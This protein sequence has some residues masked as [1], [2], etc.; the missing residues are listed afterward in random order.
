MASNAG[1]FRV[2]LLVGVLSLGPGVTVAQSIGTQCW[3]NG[4][5]LQCNSQAGVLYSPGLGETAANTF[6]SMASML[7]YAAMVRQVRAAQAQAAQAQ[8]EAARQYAAETDAARAREEA[9]LRLFSDRATAVVRAVSDSLRIYG[10]AGRRFVLALTPS[11]LDLY[12]V[13]PTASREQMQEVVWPHLQRL[14]D[15][16]TAFLSR[17]VPPA[18]PAVDSLALTPQEL[19]LFVSALQPIAQDIFMRT[20]DATPADFR[21]GMQAFVVRARVYFDSTHAV[22]ADSIR[23]ATRPVRPQRP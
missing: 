9:S 7:S 11:L 23:R 20:P 15:Q 13:N 16:F 18:K 6:S 4:G 10:E 12:R 8:A 3:N 5:V 22:R 2:A 14:N 21:S 17:V 19:T 1:S